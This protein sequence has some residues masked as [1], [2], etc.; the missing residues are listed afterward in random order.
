MKPSLLI[1]SFFIIKIATGQCSTAGP[2]N[3]SSFANNAST[4]TVAWTNTSNAQTSNDSYSGSSITLGILGSANTNYLVVT[5]FGFSLSSLSSICGIKV[6]IEKQY[7]IFIGVLSSV[8]DNEVKIVK[9]GVISGNDLGSGGW[10]SSD[11]Y[12][13][14]G[15]NSQKW[16]LT[17]TPADINSSGFGVAISTHISAGVAGLSM[18]ALVDHVRITVYYN[19]PVP[20][21]FREI[22][23]AQLGDKIKIDWS[24]ASE[25]NSSHFL[26]E[27]STSGNGE[28]ETIDSVGAAFNS[29]SDRYYS[30]NDIHPGD[31]NLYRIRQVDMDGTFIFSKIVTVKYNS[32]TGETVKVFPNPARDYVSVYS[33]RSVLSVTLIDMSG[34]VHRIDKRW[35]SG[36]F[37]K[38]PVQEFP[39]GVYSVC[40]QS[41]AEKTT[42]TI[43]IRH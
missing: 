36:N 35:Y 27:K 24:T 13:T 1:L 33:G 31:I 21:L 11:A 4:G 3:G 25:S 18:D 32:Q 9:G 30:S 16:G 12:S 28:W 2:N 10:P 5:N 42:R 23:A 19:I 8:T 41:A 17:W 39:D 43:V 37:V 26:V 15:S 34:I 40:L 7:N 6:E 20:V 14:Y 38:F 29:I 22:K